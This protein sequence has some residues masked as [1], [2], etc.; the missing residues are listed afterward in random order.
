[1]NPFV[2]SP[3]LP[4]SIAF[5]LGTVLGRFLN[6]C[7]DCFPRHETLTGQL[8]APF[9]LSPAE[10]TL[11]SARRFVHRLPIVG[12]LVPANPLS[13]GR[14]ADWQRA[15]VELGNGVLVAALVWAQLP[16][17]FTAA[18]P[19]PFAVPGME[20]LAP[21]GGSLVLQ[22]IRLALHLVLIQSVLVASVIDFERMIIPDGSTI[23]VMLL[24]LVVGTAA[25]GV[26]LVPVW[27]EDAGL[28]ALLDFGGRFDG[29]IEV[30]GFLLEHPHLHGLLV[31]ICG[32]IV[33]GGTVWAVRIIGHWA[34]G[35]E[36]MGFGDVILMAMLGSVLG[37]QPVLVI[38]FLAPLCAVV[39]VLFATLTGASREF[40][41]GPW[42]GLATFLLL[43]GWQGIWPYA[44]RFFLMGRILPFVA[45]S[46]LVLLAVLLR[47]IRLIRGDD[48]W[49]EEETEHWSSADQL[50]YQSQERPGA[51]SLSW[52]DRRNGDWPGIESGCGGLGESRWRHSAAATGWRP[53]QRP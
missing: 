41:Y 8:A 34:L 53:A 52:Q 30:P 37:W 36:A 39:V 20:S 26:W 16:Y 28:M 1:M 9:R 50:F 33:G 49:F 27:Y 17:G 35:R 51:A 6:R 32:L 29:G 21:A 3:W 42:L 22:L 43:V 11:R 46:V 23:P 15:I 12:W 14:C 10:R 31:S 38:F 2:D 48:H 5:V 19:D 44:G 25:G 18:P 4:A 47:G 7:V 24:A 13:H 45:L 40:P